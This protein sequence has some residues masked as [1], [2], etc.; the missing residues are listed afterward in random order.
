MDIEEKIYEIIEKY[1]ETGD[2]DS[3][4]EEIDELMENNENVKQFMILKDTDVFDSCGLDIYYISVAYT[5]VDGEINICGDRL[6]R[7]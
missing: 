7:C 5:D 6:T 2:I 4:E 3:C 1:D